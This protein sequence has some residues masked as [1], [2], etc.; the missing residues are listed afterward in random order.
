MEYRY[1]WNVPV[2]LNPGRYTLKLSDQTNG[3]YQTAFVNIDDP[4]QGGP[5]SHLSV[6]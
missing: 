5:P 3:Q 4:Q 2:N 1:Q 6:K